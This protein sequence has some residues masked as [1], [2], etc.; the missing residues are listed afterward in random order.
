MI[1]QL[2]PTV[3]T[4]EKR[5]YWC[6]TWWNGTTDMTFEQSIGPFTTVE[7]AEWVAHEVRTGATTRDMFS[8]VRLRDETPC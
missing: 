4:E 3:M 8:L 2:C 7:A 1:C 6:V 5:G